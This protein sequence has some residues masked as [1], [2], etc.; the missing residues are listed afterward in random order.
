MIILPIKS[1]R[2]E[3]RPL[4]GSNLVNLAKLYQH[5]LG[6]ANGIVVIPPEDF[7]HQ[8]KPPNELKIA[9]KGR[10]NLKKLWMNLLKTWTTNLSAQSLF[11]TNKISASGEA[12]YDHIL[13]HT[14]I[15]T[16]LGQL[17][18][19]QIVL[20][21]EIIKQ[22]NQRL[23]LP[24]VYHFIDDGQIRII[25]LTPFTQFPQAQ[26]M[27]DQQ[28][29]NLF[30]IKS[31]VLPYRLAVKIFMDLSDGPFSSTDLDGAII[32][33]EKIVGEE[34]KIAKLLE[35]AA[36]FPRAPIIY[37]L[38]DITHV[39]QASL[40][41]NEAEVLL[42]ARNKKHLLNCQ[43]AIPNVRSVEEFL[44]LKRE[45]ASLGIFRKGTLKMWLEFS[46]PE[47]IINLEDYL[48]AGFDGTIINLDEM[49]VM[50]TGS[51]T[52]ASSLLKFLEDGIRILNRAAVPVIFMG[53]L[54]FDDEVL[55]FVFDKGVWGIVITPSRAQGIHSQLGFALEHHLKHRVS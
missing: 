47:N 50:L 7:H 8:P 9:L 1:I 31:Q 11:F 40:L 28:K 24:Q 30:G 15:K 44:Q 49:A 55:N 3:D 20:I 26:L 18:P 21:E 42:F 6:V 17:V 33:G 35:T 23:Y 37:R 53:D 32:K 14:T 39:S 22:G 41:R 27:K 16:N 13:R 10:I 4:V 48:I 38:A 52:Q 36:R 51:N 43:L 25:K 46:V 45:L 34:K 19:E 5:N 2:E 12:F 54:S 29:E